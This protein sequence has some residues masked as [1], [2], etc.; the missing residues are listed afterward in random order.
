MALDLIYGDLAIYSS[1][2]NYPINYLTSFIKSISAKISQ[3]ELCYLKTRALTNIVINSR[4][5]DG[6][7]TFQAMLT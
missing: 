7:Q 6:Q 5:G 4:C 2:L 3:G 1:L